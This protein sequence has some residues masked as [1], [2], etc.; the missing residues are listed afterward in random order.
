MIYYL[1]NFTES[2]KKGFLGKIIKFFNVRHVYLRD[3]CEYGYSDFTPKRLKKY[4]SP[5]ELKFLYKKIMEHEE[6]FS[7]IENIPV[8]SDARI[9]RIFFYLYEWRRKYF[10]NEDMTEFLFG[11]IGKIRQRK[12]QT[13][14]YALD[15]IEIKT[16]VDMKKE[17]IKFIGENNLIL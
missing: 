17:I 7:I 13:L 12:K 8:L 15:E 5:K 11:L 2:E 3:G 4:F 14:I 1:D 6:P 9:N 16:N 10:K